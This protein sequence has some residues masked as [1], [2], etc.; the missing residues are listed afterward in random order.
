MFFLVNG[1]IASQQDGQVEPP[2]S[3]LIEAAN[4][5]SDA[6]FVTAGGAIRYFGNDVTIQQI[7]QRVENRNLPLRIVA[8]RRLQAVRLLDVLS[9]LRGRGFNNISLITTRDVVPP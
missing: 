8:D 6:V 3:I 7:G 9:E 1:T 4:P 5:P 2:K